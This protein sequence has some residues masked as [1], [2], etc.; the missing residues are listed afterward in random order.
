MVL[1]KLGSSLRNTIDKIRSAIF[2]DE[3]LINELVKEIQKAL[4]KADVNIPLVFKISNEIKQRALKEKPPEGISKKEYLVKIVYDELVKLVGG[5]EEKVEINAKP[6]KIMLVGLFGSGKT[7]QAGKLANYYKK[8]GYKVGLI[9]TDTWRP[10]SYKQLK[11]LGDKINVPVF[12]D[13]NERNPI[14]IYKKFEGKID[15]FDAVIIDTAGRDALSDEL[16]EELNKLNKVVKPNETLLVISADIGQTAEK[17]AKAF[18]E[19]SKITGIIITKMDGSAKGGGALVACSTT[20]A[21][22]KFIGVG[23]KI[24]DIERFDPKGFVGRLL[25]MGDIGVL[26]DK[27]EESIDKEKA[28]DLSQNLMNGNFSLIDLYEQMEMMKKMGPMHKVMELIPG[29]SSAK[30]PKDLLNVQEEKLKKW[31]FV[32]DSMTEKELNEPE[33]IDYSRAERIAK[34]SGTSHKDVRELIKQYKKSKKLIKDLKAY[35]N[36]PKA[37]EKLMKRMGGGKLPSGF[38]KLK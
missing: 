12:G 10:A 32:M 9:Q 35:G 30:L 23:E 5:K 36:N 34:G 11:Q 26:L 19:T 3:K 17:Q 16:I 25:G 29:L 38:G 14:K 33:I 22:V 27:I 20:G 13:P 8:R 37:I 31:K 1:D 7:T 24:N 6:T 4:I 15:E 28:M 2:V 21:K 18:N